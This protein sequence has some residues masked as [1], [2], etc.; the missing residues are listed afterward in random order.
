MRHHMVVKAS[1]G[2]GSRSRILGRGH[3]QWGQTLVRNLAV[4]QVRDFNLASVL[5]A[6]FF[7]RRRHPVWPHPWRRLRL[8]LWDK[9]RSWNVTSNIQFLPS[10]L[11]W[12]EHEALRA[13]PVH[14]EGHQGWKHGRECFSLLW[15]QQVLFWT[16][17]PRLFMY[18][19]SL[20]FVSQRI[21][22]LDEDFGP[23]KR[24]IHKGV[25]FWTESLWSSRWF[26]IHIRM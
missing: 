10:L 21:Q 19:T 4:S 15:G 22:V 1:V 26:W 5:I 11:D 9:R 25:N 3:H 13:Q 16:Y 17:N 6:S 2:A 12:G 7:F 14:E 23:G 18:L 8:H 20:L 24:P